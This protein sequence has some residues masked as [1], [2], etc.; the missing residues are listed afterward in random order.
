ML[1]AKLCPDGT[2]ELVERAQRRTLKV[3]VPFEA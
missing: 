3:P 2:M 1:S